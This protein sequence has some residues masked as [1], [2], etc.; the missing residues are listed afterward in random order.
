MDQLRWLD[1]KQHEAL[2]AWALQP[3]RNARGVQTGLVRAV[4]TL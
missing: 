2:Q 1:A 4:L 3:L